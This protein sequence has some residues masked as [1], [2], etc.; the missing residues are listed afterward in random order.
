MNPKD[1]KGV[2]AEMKAAL[3]GV[4]FIETERPGVFMHVFTEGEHSF[5]FTA[6]SIEGALY[7]FWQAGVA[8][9]RRSRQ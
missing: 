8:E 9:G 4:G 7:S 3:E 2:S 1:G 5:D 6:C